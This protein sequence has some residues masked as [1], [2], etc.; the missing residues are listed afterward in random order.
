MRFTATIIHILC[1][2]IVSVAIFSCTIAPGNKVDA[3]K[4]LEKLGGPDTGSIDKTIQNQAQQAINNGDFNRAAQMYTQLNDTHPDKKEYAIALADCLRRAGKNDAAMKV[5]N[6][7]LKKDPS[8]AEALEVKGLTFMNMGGEGFTEASKTFDKVMNID[9][10]RWRT[11]NAIG[12]LFAIKKRDKDAI[13]YYKAAL[14]NSPD[15]PGILNNL[16]LALAM[17]KQYDESINTFVRARNHLE[18]N[19]PELGQLDL[20]LALVYALDGRLDEAEQTAAPHLSK[21]ALYNNMGFYAYIAKNKQLAKSYLDM[22]LNQNPTYYERAWKNLSV[23]NGDPSAESNAD[24]IPTGDLPKNSRILNDE[25]PASEPAAP[26]HAAANPVSPAVES[27]SNEAPPVV[28]EVTNKNTPHEILQQIP[29]ALTPASAPANTNVT[30]TIPASNTAAATIAGNNSASNTNTTT[31]ADASK[32]PVTVKDATPALLPATAFAPPVTATAPSADN[33][34][35]QDKSD[36]LF[37]APQL[38]PPIIP[39]A[40]AASQANPSQ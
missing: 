11:L 34:K 25:G 32:N 37:I 31:Q 33:A 7:L 8:D 13:A 2:G 4:E 36:T 23:V 12:I 1:I 3:D 14:K 28:K 26:K 39:Q 40:A 27:S 22:A 21:A 10:N 20:N 35:P 6:D 18:S 38:T 30:A 15:N 29:P 19:S 24:D 16:A 9:G 5:I 17:E